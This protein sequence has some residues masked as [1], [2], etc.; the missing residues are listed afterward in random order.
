[1]K[2]EKKSFEIKANLKNV[3]KFNSLDA[4]TSG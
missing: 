3:Y 4:K 2:G 1:M